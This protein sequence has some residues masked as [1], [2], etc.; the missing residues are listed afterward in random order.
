METANK[1]DV[2]PSFRTILIFYTDLLLKKKAV[3][4]I[5]NI[6]PDEEFISINQ[7]ANTIADLIDF[8]LKPIYKKKQTPRGASCQ[9]QCK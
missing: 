1:N 8:N 4:E 7:L 3:K 9:L 6:G 2:F 5:I